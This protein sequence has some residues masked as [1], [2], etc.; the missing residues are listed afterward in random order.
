MDF[1][2]IIYSC[3][4]ILL[5]LAFSMASNSN[6]LIIVLPEPPWPNNT[7]PNLA[8]S[9]LYNYRHRP[10][11]F[12]LYVLRLS[13]RTLS[14]SLVA[15]NFACAFISTLP[16][17]SAKISLNNVA[18]LPYTLLNVASDSALTIILLSVFKISLSYIFT[19]LYRLAFANAA[20][21][22]TDYKLLSPQSRWISFGIRLCAN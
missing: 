22:I 10:P 14:V 18:E 4:L 17:T 16:K 13:A 3:I 6:F 2:E 1:G 19:F 21:L 12:S 9:A 20:Y 7:T 11:I 15:P 5:L 8:I